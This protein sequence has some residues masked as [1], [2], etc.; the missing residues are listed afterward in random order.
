MGE[1]ENG[2]GGECQGARRRQ[3]PPSGD[4]AVGLHC[5]SL[6]KTGE[7]LRFFDQIRAADFYKRGICR[8]FWVKMVLDLEAGA[9][10]FL[11]KSAQR[12]GFRIERENWRA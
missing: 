7:V 8:G 9:V 11:I 4:W 12:A 5:T 1:G 10:G 6:R 2:R 3:G